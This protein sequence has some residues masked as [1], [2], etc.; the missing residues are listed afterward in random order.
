MNPLNLLDDEIRPKITTEESASDMT[1]SEDATMTIAAVR[2]STTT[3][4]NRKKSEISV[5]SP[6][7][8]LN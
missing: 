1:E 5:K 7:H 8:R 4:V 2:E 3:F 6:Q